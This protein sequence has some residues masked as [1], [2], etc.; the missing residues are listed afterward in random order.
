MN[1]LPNSL[2][3]HLVGSWET[4]LSL[5]G[6]ALLLAYG[7]YTRPH[8]GPGG[9]LQS[10]AACLRLSR[11]TFLLFLITG[12]GS[13]ALGASFLPAIILVSEDSP[14]CWLVVL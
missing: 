3:A 4:P 12:T 13:S 1:I 9:L 7:L 2:T 6:P 10:L 14:V 8:R 11:S 5:K